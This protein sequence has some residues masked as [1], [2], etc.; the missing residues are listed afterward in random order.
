MRAKAIKRNKSKPLA[1]SLS[2]NG[3]YNPKIDP[4][5]RSMQGRA[6][7]LLG[8]AGAAQARSVAKNGSVKPIE[9][10]VFEGHRASVHQS[11]DGLKLGRKGKK[12]KPVNRSSKRA[13]A[14]K[15]KSGGKSS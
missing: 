14:W 10:F 2:K 12:G 15:A 9:S 13:A 6:N 8:K 7:K 4:K 3:I 11:R 1:T 5:K